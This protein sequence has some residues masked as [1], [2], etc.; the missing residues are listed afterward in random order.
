MIVGR[1]DE[2]EPV[3]LMCPRRESKRAKKKKRE[4]EQEENR[5]RETLGTGTRCSCPKIGKKET[6]HDVT[7]RRPMLFSPLRFLINPSLVG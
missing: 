1:F 5:K 4:R 2:R 6:E 7:E 3:R